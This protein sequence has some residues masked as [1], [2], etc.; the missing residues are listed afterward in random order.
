MLNLFRRRPSLLCGAPK[1]RR[2]RAAVLAL[3]WAALGLTGQV[4]GPCG[5]AFAQAPPESSEAH[6]RFQLGVQHFQA[7]RYAEALGN[8]EHAYRLKPHPLVRVNIANCYDKLHRPVEAI[9][10]FEAFLAA[11]EGSEQQRHEVEAA[12]DRLSKQLGRL[13]LRVRP[14]SALSQVDAETE[15]RHGARWLVPGS[16]RLVLSAE[17]YESS[18][19]NVQIRAGEIEEV[20][21]KLAPSRDVLASEPIRTEPIVQP[22]APLSTGPLVPVGATAGPS[23]A[24]A[25]RAQHSSGALWISGGATLVVG[26][27]ALVTGQL[28]LAANREF[29]SDVRAVRNP[30]LNE[31]QRAAAWAHG[32][33][34]SDRAES[35]AAATDVLLGLTFV[36]AGLTTY[37]WLAGGA[38]E[39]S[40]A[41]V[42]ANI[43]PGRV[44]VSAQF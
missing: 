6:R 43:S 12:V 15:A 31:L 39:Q 38:R 33:D 30:Q 37:F 24:R 34:A 35:M 21:A 14:A 3:A 9:D 41:G 16:H 17:G 44:Q 28:A 22:L 23:A 8:F 11:H 40:R 1:P 36:G 13:V 29:N 2:Q 7:G 42:R 25:A 27:T 5:R 26:I 20:D 10:A 18:S 19:R 4:A 32:V